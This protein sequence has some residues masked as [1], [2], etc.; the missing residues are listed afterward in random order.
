MAR[1]RRH[2]RNNR[3][4]GRFLGVYLLFTVILAA[5]A[6]TAGCIVFFKVHHVEVSCRLD[7]KVVSEGRTAHYTR[8]ELMEAAGIKLE[9]NL[10]MLNKNR[11]AANLLDRLPYVASV[12]IQKKLPGTL[13]LNV[14]ESKAVAAV[15]MEDKSW[16]L[17]D[18]NGK[19]LE[20]SKDRQSCSVVKGLTLLNPEAGKVIEVPDG[21]DEEVP[22]QRLQKDSLIHLLKPLQSYGLADEVKTINLSS[23]SELT[24]NYAG[25]IKVKIPL[26]ADF[27]YKV[28]YFSEILTEYIP[29]HWSEKDTGTL[30]M[31]YSDGHPHLTKN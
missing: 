28:K 23:D 29:K 20:Q 7:G 5:A 30:D 11:A 26:E 18:V 25:R 22:S 3:N 17:M 21:S 19:L 24:L 1:R 31:T 15:Q 8:E 27:E 10:C 13:V 9:E 6:I 2:R 4:G 12:S 14:T 16:W